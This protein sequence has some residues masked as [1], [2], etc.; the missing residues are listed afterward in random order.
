MRQISY[1]PANG[2]ILDS[3]FAQK[4][5]FGPQNYFFEANISKNGLK[6]PPLAV[7]CANLKNSLEF[8]IDWE[9]P[10]FLPVEHRS[11]N[12]RCMAARSAASFFAKP[13]HQ[14][15]FTHSTYPPK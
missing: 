14:R 11:Y 3:Y 2:A 10:L 15:D 5:K 13:W 4:S 8:V 12:Y 6:N 9:V 1:P 7:K